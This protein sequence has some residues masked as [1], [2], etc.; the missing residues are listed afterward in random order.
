MRGII[1][2]F[3]N[4]LMFTL[5]AQERDSVF[6]KFQDKIDV[7]KSDKEKIDLMLDFAEKQYEYNF[8]FAKRMVEEAVELINNQSVIDE[9]QLAKAYTIQGIINRREGKYPESLDYNL[10]A[11]SIY[12]KLNDSMYGSDIMHNMGM[13]YR[14]QKLHNK[15]IQLYKE[16]IAIKALINDTH[17]L[18]ASYNMMGVSFRQSKKLDSAFVCYDK[19]R[20]LFQSID[21]FEDVQRVNNNLVA[22]YR[23]QKKYDLA[24]SL[25]QEN[26][27]RSKRKNKN[28]SLSAAYFNLSTLYKRLKDYSK[29]LAYADSALIVAKSENFRKKIS[30]AYLR[31][32]FLN[33]KLGDYKT[34]Y[35]DYRKFNRHSDSIFNI[36][37][38]KRIQASELNY[39]FQQEKREV[40]L[41][42]KQE[43]EKKQL[44]GI[45]LLLVLA[46]GLIIGYLIFRIYK[47]RA[48]ILEE[49]VEKEKAQKELLDAKVKV[50]EEETKKLVADNT[51]R[52][53]FKQELLDQIKSHILPD[54]TGEL[55]LKLNSLISEL[56][57]QVTT[58]GKLSEI[59][60]KITDVNQGFDAKLRELYPKLTKTER[61]V[62]ALLR[63]NL[64]IKEIMTVRNSSL[65]AVKSTRYRIRKKMGLNSGEEL[66]RF[67]QSI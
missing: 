29:S 35:F 15:A 10:K 43:K 1:F 63:V 9:K 4:L 20:E 22:L 17:G 32:S 52:L 44:Y 49:K 61:E 14:S 53:E 55:K 28:F 33:H 25:A 5:C 37:N 48:L 60:S 11:K 27:I 34:A 50:G 45:L 46:S 6:I 59:Q 57:L 8:S 64:S 26:I 23:D 30:K 3:L 21:S 42:A 24:I 58:E 40:E 67:I 39:K 38:I 2:V 54:A 31:K 51:M 47:N 19:A 12:E 62:C 66:E 56:Q 16:S 13:V 41:L 65:D 18:A 7:S 36:E